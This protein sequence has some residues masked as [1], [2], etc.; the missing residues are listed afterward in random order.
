MEKLG[1]MDKKFWPTRARRRL[2]APVRS[3]NG[4]EAV[5]LIGVAQERQ[6]AV[7]GVRRES[8]KHRLGWCGGAVVAP[9]KLLVKVAV[10]VF[11]MCEFSCSMR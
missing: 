9:E 8:N 4:A 2:D 1:R 11:S 10:G 7:I 5:G 3:A 6:V